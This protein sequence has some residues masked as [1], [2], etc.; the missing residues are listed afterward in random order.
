MKRPI[1]SYLSAIKSIS[2]NSF[3]E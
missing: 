3:S 2:V 1:D